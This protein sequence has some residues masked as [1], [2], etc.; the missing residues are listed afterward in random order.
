V[1]TARNQAQRVLLRAEVVHAGG[2]IVAH[3]TEISPTTILLD[4]PVPLRVG[5][6]VTIMLSFPRLVGPFE[7]S[8]RV[9][10]VR[11]GDGPGNA[12]AV[13]CEVLAASDEARAFLA[14]VGVGTRWPKMAAHDSYRCLLVEDNSFIRDLFVY[15]MDKYGRTRG[16]PVSLSLAGDADQAWEMLAQSDFDMAIIDYYLPTRNGSALIERMRA[17]PR[18]AD[19][20][21]VAISV[22]GAEAREASIAAGADLFLDKPIVM[23]DLF[24]TL[25]ML[26]L[27]QAGR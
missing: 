6:E 12:G 1:V 4:C 3:T 21:V 11:R 23:R 8:A 10:E 24:T 14:D 18:H 2:R 15:G 20:P 17:L 26:T 22:G 25:D 9:T 19:L 13:V 7:V 5:S 27:R 16:A